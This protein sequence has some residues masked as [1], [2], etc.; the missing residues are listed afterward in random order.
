M[1]DLDEIRA[2][3]EGG[4]SITD[5]A[6]EL[7]ITPARVSQ[8]VTAMGL[9]GSAVRKSVLTRLSPEQ[10]ENIIKMYNEG[11][12]V[13]HINVKYG[14]NY[15][16]FYRLLRD[17]GVK[18]RDR[19]PE[20]MEDREERIQQAL[21]LYMRDVP[22]QQ[23]EAET[24]IRQPIMHRELHAR[25][26]PLRGRGKYARAK[27]G[28]EGDTDI[29]DLA[30]P[31][32]REENILQKDAEGY[33]DALQKYEEEQKLKAFSHLAPILKAS[34]PPEISAGPETP[35]GAPDAD[36]NDADD[37]DDDGADDTELGPGDL[38]AEKNFS[39]PVLPDKK[40]G[41]QRPRK[42]KSSW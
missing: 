18:Y 40:Q 37:A 10:V 6:A 14:L 11:A 32:T 13:I 42:L 26:I 31:T 19:G 39:D 41:R 30:E 1:A 35:A 17:N 28:L 16:A 36:D 8:L 7:D 23:I 21:R 27:L 29:I 2:M 38:G 33:L 20:A 12:S 34:T 5:I 9:S 15:N 3:I 25:G 4:M 22:I 24:G